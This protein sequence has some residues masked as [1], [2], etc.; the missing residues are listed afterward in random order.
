MLFP[1]YKVKLYNEMGRVDG[2]FVKKYDGFL[3]YN[4][5]RY[6]DIKN[7]I[8]YCADYKET[9]VEFLS[10]KLEADVMEAIL[11]NDKC[12]LKWTEDDKQRKLVEASLRQAI[13]GINK[14]LEDK[15][16]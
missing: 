12:E 13:K 4:T 11:D 10:E 5:I 15:Y 9:S 1:L 16:K 3:F 8:Q 6:L 7:Y 14:K 2:F